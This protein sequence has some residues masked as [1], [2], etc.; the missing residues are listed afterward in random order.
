MT[1]PRLP[2]W[3]RRLYPLNKRGLLIQV[4]LNR[5][6]LKWQDLAVVH[7]FVQAMAT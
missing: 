7:Q 1:N 6:R 2:S 3:I 5:D 4:D